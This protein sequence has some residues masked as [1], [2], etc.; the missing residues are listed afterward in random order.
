MSD[1]NVYGNLEIYPLVE[2]LGAYGG[3]ERGSSDGMSDWEVYEKLEVSPFGELLGA[4]V[5]LR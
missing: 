3:S 5:E 1:G 4:E 2:A